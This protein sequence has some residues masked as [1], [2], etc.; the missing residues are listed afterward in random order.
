M[1]LVSNVIG[2]IT[3]MSSHVWAQFT[4]AGSTLLVNHGL[5]HID[6][7]FVVTAIRAMATPEP[8]FLLM[9]FL[10]VILQMI[11]ACV[12]FVTLITFH[13]RFIW[14]SMNCSHVPL[15]TSLYKFLPT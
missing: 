12:G 4:G 9:H 1:V 15:V 13:T 5:M 10:H 8:D 6:L 7:I 11:S 14:A 2:K 3:L